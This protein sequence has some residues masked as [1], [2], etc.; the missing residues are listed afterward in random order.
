M[1]LKALMLKKRLDDKK[2]LLAALR[3]DAESRPLRMLSPHSRMTRQKTRN[4]SP[5]WNR[6]SQIPSASSQRQSR[7]Q[8]AELLPPRRLLRRKQLKERVNL[9]WV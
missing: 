9:L 4:R 1:A 8:I 3:E 2:K 7:R 6:R 5:L